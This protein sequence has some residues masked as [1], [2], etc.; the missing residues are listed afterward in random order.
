MIKYCLR[1]WIKNEDKLK[2][3]FEQDKNLENYD[4]LDL[5]KNTVD[6]ILNTKI[7]EY[8]EYLW[9]IDGITVIDNGD[10]QGTLLFLIPE[11]TYQPSECEYLMTYVNYGSCSGC[12]TLQYIQA[13]YNDKEYQ[14]KELMSLCKDIICN[15]IKPYNYGW[16]NE[17][18]FNTVEM[19][20]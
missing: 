15:I 11:D 17:E 4:Y 19:E 3:F 2:K 9:D 5:V 8:K 16:R 20:D 1:K 10:Y 7:E 12:D 6:I 14:V 18:E 13:Y